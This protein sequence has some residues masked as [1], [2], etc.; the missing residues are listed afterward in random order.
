MIAHTSV[1]VSDYTTSKELYAKMLAPLGYAIGM[2][3]SEHKVTGFIHDGRL[4]FWSDR[5]PLQ[6]D[7]SEREYAPRRTLHGRTCRT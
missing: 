5:L 4:D 7:E 6:S 2:D 3:L 1:A